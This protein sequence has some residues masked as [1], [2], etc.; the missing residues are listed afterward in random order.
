M[1]EKLYYK[2]AYLREFSAVIE[3][4]DGQRILLDRTAFYPEG[5]GQG[6]DHGELELPGGRK[7]TVIDVQEEGEKIW[8][9]IREP[10]TS[11]GRNSEASDNAGEVPN[12]ESEASDTAVEVPNRG[13]KVTGRIDWNRRFDHMQQH[14]GEHIVSG[15]ICRRF[16][17]DNVGFHLGEDS[18]TID[19]NTVISFGQAL[20]IEEEANAY[21]REDHPFEVLWPSA[22]ELETLEYRSKKELTGAVRI[23]R[24]PGADCCA[25]CGTHVSGSAQVGLVKFLSAGRFHDGTRLELLCG[26]RAVDFLSVNF[27]ENKASAV[28]LSSKEDQT[29]DHVKKLI[30]E[31]LRLKTELSDVQERLFRMRA[32][33]LREKGD[34]LLTGGGMNAVQA[35]IQADLIADVCSGT[36]AVFAE[37]EEGYNYAVIRKDGEISD[38]IKVLNQELE[39]RGGGRNGFAQGSVAAGKEKIEAF[40]GAR[41]F[42]ISGNI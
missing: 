35:R 8:H 26:K 32:E 22:G 23:A 36:A 24:F 34:V 30:E 20:E 1:T 7:V 16:H 42:F 9:V 25:C 21:I 3:E 13:N 11:P 14:S 19:F 33:G 37:K 40:F 2:D 12:R 29:S 41:G 31:N 10:L 4:M 5:G 28:L 39:G 38:L 27:R 18:V 17:C 15:M 6:A